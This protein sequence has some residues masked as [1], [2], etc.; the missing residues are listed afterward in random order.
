MKHLE[1]R[2]LHRAHAPRAASTHLAGL[3][4]AGLMS[5]GI[6]L[7]GCGLLD[8]ELIDDLTTDP[9]SPR[10]TDPQDNPCAVVKCAGG[11]QCVVLKSLPPQTQCVPVTDPEPTGCYSSESCG[12]GLICSTE[13]GACERPPGC[14]ENAPCPAVCYGTCVPK[15][16]PAEARCISSNECG[17]GLRCSTEL[18]D[19]QSCSD[20]P[21]TICPAVCYGTCAPVDE[22]PEPGSCR[23]DADCVLISNYCGTR[24]CTC[25][26]FSRDRPSPAAC[27]SDQVACLVDPCRD[28]AA[29]CQAGVCRVAAAQVASR[30]T[31][32]QLLGDDTSCK[33]YDAWKRAA[34]ASCSQQGMGLEQFS[35]GGGTC[36]GGTHQAKYTCC[37]ADR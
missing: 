12:D 33:S 2:S 30:C 31:D 36:R 35:V 27:P 15:A 23:S 6:G 29:V 11:T 9:D 13:Q 16:K 37:K 5:F 18:G 26:A 24:P 4:I 14:D 22:K 25:E 10:P 8:P 28:A 3:L 17:P 20:D 1:T 7:T 34:Y 32:A 19:C 21:A